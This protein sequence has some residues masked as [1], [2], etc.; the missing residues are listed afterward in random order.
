MQERF[1]NGIPSHLRKKYVTGI[2]YLNQRKGNHGSGV[3]L[4]I[5]S[6]PEASAED[7][8]GIGADIFKYVPHN[9]VF[10]Y[11]TDVMDE[12]IYL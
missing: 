10:D 6:S 4:I 2:W 5:R 11:E 12:N 1:P 9:P 7:K 3:L 8:R